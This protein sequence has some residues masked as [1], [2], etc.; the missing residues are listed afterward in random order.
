MTRE[1]AEGSTMGRVSGLKARETV[2]TWTPA[3]SATCFMVTVRRLPFDWEYL[4]FTFVS[5]R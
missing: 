1:I 5:F 3:S 4:A 2:E